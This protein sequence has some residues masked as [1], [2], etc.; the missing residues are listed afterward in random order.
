[1]PT[2]DDILQFLFLMI[3]LSLFTYRLI[4]TYAVE[5]ERCLANL[6]PHLENSP[7]V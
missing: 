1:M 6:S 7:R 4:L 5:A 2:L 3:E